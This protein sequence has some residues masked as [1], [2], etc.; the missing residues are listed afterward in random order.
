M[1]QTCSRATS[2]LMNL[3]VSLHSRFQRLSLYCWAWTA[4]LL[5]CLC[6][7]STLK[8][9]LPI[10]VRARTPLQQAARLS[11]GSYLITSLFLPCHLKAE[12]T[13]Y[14]IRENIS[15]EYTWSRCT[16]RY[17]VGKES[18]AWQDLSWSWCLIHSYLLLGTIIFPTAAQ[19]LP[20]GHMNPLSGTIFI[21][22][23]YSYSAISVH[24][25]FQ[26]N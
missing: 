23:Y 12:W 14:P 26:T 18:A 2:Y 3:S 22:I 7:L 15:S 6:T 20:L 13:L 10:K 4:V 17:Q 9:N 1:R 11:L 8:K 16:V 24:D 19:P 5:D 25:V 21:I